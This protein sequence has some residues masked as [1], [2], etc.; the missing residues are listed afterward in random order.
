LIGGEI[1]YAAAGQRK[2]F[3]GRGGGVF[4]FEFY[5]GQGGVLEVLGFVGDFFL[6]VG[7]YVRW[8]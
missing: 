4:V 2:V 7:V 6:V 8:C 1:G 5:K 3:A